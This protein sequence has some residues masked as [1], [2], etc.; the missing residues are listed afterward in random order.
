MKLLKLFFVF[1]LLVL[2]G[3]FT[4]NYLYGE[5]TFKGDTV[6]DIEEDIDIPKVIFVYSDP[7]SHHPN[8]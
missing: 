4:V 2:G 8:G 5:P 3:T 6:F 7:N 1:I